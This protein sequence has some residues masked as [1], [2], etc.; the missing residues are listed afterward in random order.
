MKRQWICLTS[1]CAA[2]FLLLTCS[3]VHVSDTDTQPARTRSQ[4]YSVVSLTTAT[5]PENRRRRQLGVGETVTLT[6]VPTPAGE[7]TW[8]WE[9]EGSLI[10]V[11][12]PSVTFTAGESA[13]RPTISVEV[14]GERHSITF[15]V[16]EPDF[17]RG[18]ASEEIR[19]VSAFAGAAMRLHIEV[20]PLD[21]S[22]SNVEVT[23]ISGDATNL[24]GYFLAQDR[25][26]LY[27][28]AAPGWFRLNA[29]NRTSD[30]VQIGCLSPPWS[31][32]SLE[33]HI[34]VHWRVVGSKD[35]QGKPLKAPA[36][37]KVSMAGASG[38]VTVTKLGHSVTRTPPRWRA[39]GI[40]GE[41]CQ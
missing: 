7:A 18:Y 13:S 30:T 34:P 41:I 37:Q 4:G 16:V 22:F 14:E 36:V 3:C 2:V 24:R 39:A 25:K 33:W 40:V 21:V 15:T 10:P 27:H 23:E 38:T 6:V 17:E 12:G 1:R 11:T 9:G 8:T 29:R 20:H 35:E 31:E 5:L 19:T 32:G 26:Q 28:T